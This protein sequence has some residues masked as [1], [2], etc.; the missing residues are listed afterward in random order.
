MC[1]Y[2]NIYICMYM[3]MYACMYVLPCG[4]LGSTRQY[5][6]FVLSIYCCYDSNKQFCI[7]CISYIVYCVAYWIC[8]KFPGQPP[9]LSY[10]RSDYLSAA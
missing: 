6:I 8:I 5:T 1:V 10:V 2:V 3:S 9:K 4:P 7:Y